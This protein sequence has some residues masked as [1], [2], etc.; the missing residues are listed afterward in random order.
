MA[1]ETMFA[2]II[3]EAPST[4]K[5]KPAL[6]PVC[7]LCGL[8]QDKT[9]HSLNHAF[10]LSYLSRL[11]LRPGVSLTFSARAFAGLIT[12]AAFSPM[13]RHQTSS[14]TLLPKRGT[15]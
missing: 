15:I 5:I 4:S 9:G 2:Q 12:G 10:P 14:S 6:L 13:L 11:S 1:G 3:H 7:C 8:V